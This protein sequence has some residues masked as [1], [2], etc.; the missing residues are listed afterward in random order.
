MEQLL[1]AGMVAPE[2]FTLLAADSVPPQVVTGVGE[3]FTVRLP[4]NEFVKPTA[5]SG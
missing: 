1:P 3:L 5:A 2:R 4:G